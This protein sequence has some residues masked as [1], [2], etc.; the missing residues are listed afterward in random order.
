[1]VDWIY[2]NCVVSECIYQNRFEAW[3]MVLF[4]GRTHVWDCPI[5]HLQPVT[6]NTDRF[7]LFL[8]KLPRVLS[9]VVTVIHV[10]AFYPPVL[11]VFHWC[12]IIFPY[13]SRHHLATPTSFAII[14]III[15]LLIQY[16]RNTTP[17]SGWNLAKAWLPGSRLFV[18]QVHQPGFEAPEGQPS[19]LDEATVSMGVHLSLH[20]YDIYGIHMYSHE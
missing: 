14:I 12:Y 2:S 13:F 10:H 17:I 20:M 8:N 4:M 9:I 5:W 1:M 18:C 15:L 6:K 7:P 19:V 16:K 3:G 11:H